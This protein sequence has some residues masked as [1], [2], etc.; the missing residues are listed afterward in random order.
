MV[1]GGKGAGGGGCE[2]R[3]EEAGTGRRLKVQS[4][5]GSGGQRSGITKHGVYGRGRFLT[6][7]FI[8]SHT[9]CPLV[10]QRRTGNPW[11]LFLSHADS[12]PLL[13]L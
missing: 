3:A 10:A 11:I 2:R 5:S 6:W 9:G 1:G 7:L 13:S 4:T 12:L 8:H